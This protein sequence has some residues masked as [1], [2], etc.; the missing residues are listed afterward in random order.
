[1]KLIWLRIPVIQKGFNRVRQLGKI[2]RNPSRP[3]LA[4]Q[5]V[6][7]ER[8]PELIPQRAKRPPIVDISTGKYRRWVS[9]PEP[10]DDRLK[11]ITLSNEHFCSDSHLLPEHYYF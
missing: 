5:L 1:M 7:A 11:N 3:I 9:R 4:E 2:G 6:A 10:V 8:R